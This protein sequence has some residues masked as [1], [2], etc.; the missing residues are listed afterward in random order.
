MLI[1]DIKK[2]KM[3][4]LKTHD[5]AAQGAYAIVM[6]KHLD[7]TINL[8]SQNK[9]PSDADTVS[10]I[11]KA[12]KE[13]VEE[14][15]MYRDNSRPEQASETQH[16]I[17]VLN[18]FLPAMMPEEEVKKIIEGLADKSM[19]NIMMVFKTQYAGKAD[20]SVVSRLAKEYQG[21]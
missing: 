6:N 13:L 18:K 11:Q 9:T 15:D 19:K 17:D 14:R 8:R 10:L 2:A 7:L 5:Q 1:D 3:E 16:Q 21:K 20:M 4:A 12:I